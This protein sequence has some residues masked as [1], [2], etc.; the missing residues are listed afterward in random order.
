[1]KG[2]AKSTSQEEFDLL[3]CH[4]CGKVLSDGS[5]MVKDRFHLGNIGSTSR[6]VLH[7]PN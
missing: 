5:V 3:K 7:V 1:M 2:W 4:Y 6:E